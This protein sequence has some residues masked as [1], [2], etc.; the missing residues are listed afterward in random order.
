MKGGCAS[1]MRRK[2]YFFSFTTQYYCE[3]RLESPK[4]QYPGKNFEQ[5]SIIKTKSPAGAT[6]RGFTFVPSDYSCEMV[7]VTVSVQVPVC[8]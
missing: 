4:C 3:Y 5:I 8:Q 7:R 2:Y 1:E 6:P